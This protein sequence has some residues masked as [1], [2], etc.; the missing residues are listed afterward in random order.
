ME[1]KYTVSTQLYLKNGDKDIRLGEIS[2]VEI[3]KYY[4]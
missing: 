1:K 3:E 2:D 4:I